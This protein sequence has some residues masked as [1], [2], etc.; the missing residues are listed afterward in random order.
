M[1]DHNCWICLEEGGKLVR[2][3]KCPEDRV[4]HVACLSR[5]QLYSTGKPEATECRFCGAAY[6]V[7]ESAHTV[8]AGSASAHTVYA[9]CAWRQFLPARPGIVA[10]V[11]PECTEGM[12]AITLKCNGVAYP[13][14]VHPGEEGVALLAEHFRVLGSWRRTGLV[15]NNYVLE[16]F[17]DSGARSTRML[18]FETLE[19]MSRFVCDTVAASPDSDIHVTGTYICPWRGA[20]VGRVSEAGDAHSYIDTLIASVSNGVAQRA[21]D[22]VKVVGKKLVEIFA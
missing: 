19:A 21:F 11:I 8:Y 18:K 16:R 14:S 1:Q 7:N 9:S 6:A 15:C 20:D 4:V 12:P 2:A 13:V 10:P 17:N 5:W 3:C 22:A